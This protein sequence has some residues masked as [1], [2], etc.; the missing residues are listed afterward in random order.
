MALSDEYAF[1]LDLK[2]RIEKRGVTQKEY[3]AQ[4][5]ISEQYLSD[6]L[7]GSRAPGKK[8]LEAIGWERVTYYRL[9]R[10]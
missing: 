1:R 8:L 9:V 10:E 3:A 2:R 4:I 5:G 6:V 7:S